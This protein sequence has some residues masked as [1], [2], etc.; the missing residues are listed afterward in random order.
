MSIVSADRNKTGRD[1][2]D[3]RYL[4]FHLG[5]EEFGIPLLSVKE[6]IAIP[7]IIPVPQ[8]PNYMLGIMNLRGQVISIID[9]R[10][11]LTIKPSETAETAVII[12]DMHPN[13]IGIVV[14]S[15]DS[16]I[17]PTKEQISEKPE[18]Y[19]QK[20]SAYIESV[21]R[22][23]KRLVLLLDIAKTLNAS[24]QQIIAKAVESQPKANAA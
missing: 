7:E 5:N 18:V 2:M 8:T 13:H 3:N 21:Y 16:V 22:T 24:D 17:H 12:C 1:G 6:V 4:C 23:D 14:D 20:T 9:M 15:I 10:T 19:S 11:K